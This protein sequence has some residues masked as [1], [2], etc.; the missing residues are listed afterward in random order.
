[1]HSTTGAIVVALPQG[2]ASRPCMHRVHEP[3]EV[4]SAL[5]SLGKTRL[6]WDLCVLVARSSA[7]DNVIE[8]HKA[9]KDGFLHEGR[10]DMQRRPIDVILSQSL[11]RSCFIKHGCPR[12]IGSS[13]RSGS[14]PVFLFP[15]PVILTPM[16]Q[17]KEAPQPPP[18]LHFRHQ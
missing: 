2:F 12:R 8:L 17:L 11:S 9:I 7:G 1:M 18:S 16:P 15:V 13:R 14:G 6:C 5:H 4:K 10:M 3:W